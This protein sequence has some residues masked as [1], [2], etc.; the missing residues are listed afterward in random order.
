M[1]FELNALIRGANVHVEELVRFSKMQI[2]AD[3]LAAARL[4]AQIATQEQ[5]SVKAD[6]AS[7]ARQ[8]TGYASSSFFVISLL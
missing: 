7:L 5:Q 1:D 8:S 3:P 4:K 6:L 2:A